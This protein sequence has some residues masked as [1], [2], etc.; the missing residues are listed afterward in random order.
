MSWDLLYAYYAYD[1][2]LDILFYLITLTSHIFLDH[3][4]TK[5]LYSAVLLDQFEESAPFGYSKS[6]V[7][8]IQYLF[9]GLLLYPVPIAEEIS[10]PDLAYLKRKSTKYKRY[11]AL[12]EYPKRVSSLRGFNVHWTRKHLYGYNCRTSLA[13]IL[14]RFWL[15]NKKSHQ[16]QKKLTYICFHFVYSLNSNFGIS[17][18]VV[19]NKQM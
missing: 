7:R 17:Y 6:K 14:F 12:V 18:S 19:V 10:R 16:I 9:C 5:C 13:Y 3:I 8:V 1:F 4:S 2:M 11:I 15:S